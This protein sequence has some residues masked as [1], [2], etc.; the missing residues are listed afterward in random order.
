MPEI[1]IFEYLET[2]L[3]Q[4]SKEEESITIEFKEE[5]GEKW[6][7]IK[8]DTSSVVKTLE[9]FYYNLKADFY[10]PHLGELYIPHPQIDDQYKTIK[11]RLPELKIPNF[12]IGMTK[13]EILS[14]ELKEK[15]NLLPQI[16]NIH[17]NDTQLSLEFKKDIIDITENRID[18]YLY[19]YRPSKLIFSKKESF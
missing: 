2:P 5:K 13:D 1:H 14:K 15:W 11:Y 6:D 12:H 19:V 4:D 17:L 9:G 18:G 7:T 3:A 8:W 10:M 16:A